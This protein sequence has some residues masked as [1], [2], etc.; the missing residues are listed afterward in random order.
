M[1]LA[2]VIAALGL[3][4]TLGAQAQ[5]VGTLGQGNGNFVSLSSAGLDNGNIATLSGG[6]VLPASD[7]RFATGAVPV[8]SVLGNAV[9]EASP[10]TGSL[11]TLSF[12]GAGQGEVG[13]MWGSPDAWNQLTVTTTG[14]VQTLFT[15][16]SLGLATDVAALGTPQ[17]VNFAASAGSM[18]TALTFND[19]P[20][21]AGFESANFSVA[22]VPEPET[23]A[24]MVAG[25]SCVMFVA[26]R[27]QN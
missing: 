15:A 23:W 6:T 25:L 21:Y 10:G 22:A 18:I 19:S 1:K 7:P 20:D 9:L 4:S 27:R 11:A 13:F 8:S 12:T 3:F 26:R 24:L 2:H 16:A 14:G 17:Y 5:V